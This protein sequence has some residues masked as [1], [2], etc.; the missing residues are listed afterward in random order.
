MRTLYYSPGACSLAVHIVLEWIG[1]PYEAI[2]IDLRHLPD[3]YHHI[4]PAGAVPALDHGGEQALTQCAAILSYLAQRHPNLDLLDERSPEHAAGLTIW[5]A[6]LTGDLHPAFWPVF[7]PSRYTTD[8]EPDALAKVRDA[9]L[10]LVRSKL[11]LLE[12][13]LTGRSWIVGD[14]RTIVDAYATPMLNWGAAMLPEGLGAFPNLGVHRG[15]MRSDPA[16]RRAM[17]AEGLPLDSKGSAVSTLDTACDRSDEKPTASSVT[18]DIVIVGGGSAGAVLARR[19]SERADRRVLLLEA[20]QIHGPWAYP[21]NVACSDVVG[22]VTGV[23]W[24]YK[25]EPGWIGRSIGATRGRVLG[26]SSAINGAVAIR[27]RPQDL[28]NWNLP[29]LVVRRP[30]ACVPPPGRVGVGRRDP[31]RARRAVPCAADDPRRHHAHAECVHRRRGHRR[32]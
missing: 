28:R 1:E 14:K 25:T 10:D 8:T 4:N 18:Y 9:G 16:V 20:G 22:D 23:D 17:Q 32:L 24:G 11:A 26:G 21:P 31:A 2:R 30:A 19:L 12:R 5:T 15:R 3:D 6:F 13:Q 29:R 27:A 7:M